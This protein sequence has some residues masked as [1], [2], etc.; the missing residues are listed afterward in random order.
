MFIKELWYVSRVPNPKWEKGN[1]CFYGLLPTSGQ[2]VGR[3]TFPPVV[4]PHVTFS[5]W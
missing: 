3:G 5:M 4:N 1:P 2:L